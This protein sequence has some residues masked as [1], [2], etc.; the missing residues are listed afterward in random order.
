MYDPFNKDFGPLSIA[1]THRYCAELVRLLNDPQYDQVKIYHHCGTQFDVL[2]NHVT[3][4]GCFQII[5]LGR[6]AEEAWE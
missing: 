5:I 2:A 1:L 3:L 4:V 6:S